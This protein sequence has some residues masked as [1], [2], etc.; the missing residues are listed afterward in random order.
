[1]NFQC[2]RTV[3]T[4]DT[5]IGHLLIGNSVFCHTLEDVVRKDESAKVYG[6]TAIPAG[7]Y[8]VTLEYSN[9]FKKVL[10]RIRNVPNFDGILLHGGNTAKDTDGCILV[11]KNI[12]DERTIQGSMSDDLI[13][14]LKKHDEPNWIEIVNTFPYFGV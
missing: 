3:Y 12:V 2:I 13:E 7:R 10:P 1:M 6:Q 8:P 11:A 5:T 9:H 14:L 4:P